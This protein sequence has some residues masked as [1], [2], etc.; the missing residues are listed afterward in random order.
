MYLLHYMVYGIFHYF[1]QHSTA[2]TFLESI[3]ENTG[4][5]NNKKQKSSLNIYLYASVLLFAKYTSE[6]KF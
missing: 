2:N 5:F 6:N 3:Q 4:I 1:E